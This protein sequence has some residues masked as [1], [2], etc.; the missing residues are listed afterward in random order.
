MTTQ[1]QE[2]GVCSVCP[3]SHRAVAALWVFFLLGALIVSNATTDVLAQEANL[4]DMDISQA[5]TDALIQDPGV[6]SNRVDVVTSDGVVTLSQMVNNILA[7]DRA[8]EVAQTVKGV[9]AVV[10]TIDVRAPLLSD[11]D[12]QQG[13][14]SAW[15]RNS[16]TD[17]YELAV[18]VNNGIA[19]LSGTADSWQKKQLA[20]TVAKGVRGVRGIENNIDIRYEDDRSDY[21]IE[22]EIK[23]ALRWDVL[24]DDTLIAVDVEDGEVTLTG[25]VGSAAEKTYAI[26]DAWVLGV[27][28]VDADGLDV[29]SW[30]RD[31]RFRQQKYVQKND[32]EIVTAVEDALIYDP[33]VIS[34]DIDVSASNGIV[35]LSG[36]VDNLKAKRAA[37]QTARNVVGV[38]RVTNNITVRSATVSD[39]TIRSKAENALATDPYVERY[40]ITL[41]VVD[42][43]VYLYGDV[44]DYFEKARAEDVVSAIEGVVAVHNRLNVEDAYD[45]YTYD[46]YVDDW[47]LYDYSWVPD[48]GDRRT[49]KSDWEIQEDIESELFWSP[50]V[51]SDEITVTVDDGVAT[52]SGTVETMSERAAAEKNAYDGG[53]VAVDNDLNVIY[54][55]D[56]Y[57]P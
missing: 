39:S 16:A 49:A 37:A 31:D 56:Y 10:N 29:A 19:T 27:A 46:P 9:R 51:D 24:V 17:A 22:T 30:A 35:T 20:A 3:Q 26:A 36:K 21:K 14:R 34:F 50:F 41:A 11:A 44:D 45:T 54:G 8:A 57:N 15:L 42:N 12:I 6:N 23:E 53:A 28:S 5:V 32:T 38:W 43:E 55:P 25:T 47:S 1:E 40:D 2:I 13:I 33:R 4:S 18:S 7:K 52:L 48:T